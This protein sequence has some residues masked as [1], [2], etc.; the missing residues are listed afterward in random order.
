MESECP[1]P[2]Q[3][4]NNKTGNEQISS[5]LLEQRINTGREAKQFTWEGWKHWTRSSKEPYRTLFTVDKKLK[6]ELY[7]ESS[8]NSAVSMEL[9]LAITR[10]VKC[11]LDTSTETNLFRGDVFYTEYLEVFKAINKLQLRRPTNQKIFIFRP[12][13]FQ[14]RK[15]ETRVHIISRVLRHSALQLL[16]VSF[17]KYKFGPYDLLC[18]TKSSFAQVC[19]CHN[20]GIW[21]GDIWKGLV[22]AASREQLQVEYKIRT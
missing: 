14:L 1:I 9:A 22:Q 6:D 3:K 4:P 12:T 17:T 21:G 16:L 18:R 8:Y 19:I 11:V 2:S 5:P 13:I 10:P 20:F 7:H 15:T